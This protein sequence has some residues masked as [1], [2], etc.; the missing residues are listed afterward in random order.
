M[1]ESDVEIRF[2]IFDTPEN[3]MEQVKQLLKD[4]PVPVTI[5]VVPVDEIRYETFPR[6]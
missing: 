6:N 5:T 1:D 3:V 4:F 2:R